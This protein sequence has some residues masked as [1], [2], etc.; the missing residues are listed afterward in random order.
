MM[1][2]NSYCNNGKIYFVSHIEYMIRKYSPLIITR[3]DKR[4]LYRDLINQIC[5]N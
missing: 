1:A 4:V 5:K 3:I 2:L